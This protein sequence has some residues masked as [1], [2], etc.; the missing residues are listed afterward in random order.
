MSRSTTAD[1]LLDIARYNTAVQEGDP[2]GPVVSAVYL[3]ERQ[4]LLPELLANIAAVEA[5][6]AA[7]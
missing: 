1:R 4:S 2:G 6:E 3:R 7:E 5:L